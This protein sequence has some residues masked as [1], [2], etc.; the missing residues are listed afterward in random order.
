M[1]GKTGM[2]FNILAWRRAHHHRDHL[3]GP[4]AAPP[5]VLEKSINKS[6]DLKGLSGIL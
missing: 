5:H 4:G 3:R 1:P 2:V 6:I